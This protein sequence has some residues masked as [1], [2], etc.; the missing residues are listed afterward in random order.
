MVHPLVEEGFVE[1]VKKICDDNNITFQGKSKLYDFE[2][3]D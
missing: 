2:P 1:L 3:V